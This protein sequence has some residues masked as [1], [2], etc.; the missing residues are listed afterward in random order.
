MAI[1]LK[2]PLPTLKRF[3]LYLAFIKKNCFGEWVSTN[4]ISQ[5]LGIKPITIRKDINYLEIIGAPKKGFNVKELIEK[6]DKVVGADQSDDFALVGSWGFG[7]AFL[8]YKELIPAN[9]NIKLG[10]D[11]IKKEDLSNHI[12]IYPIKKLEDLL[13]RL[14]I[15]NIILS[16]PEDDIENIY[17]KL[18]TLNVDKIWNIS[19][20]YL[21]SNQ[22][23]K[24]YYYNPINNF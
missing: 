7:S 16:V 13:Q 22:D 9:M 2:I 21:P 8:N 6:M 12:P 18:I 17:N 11:Y 1:E 19:P 23:I 3:S 14:A 10:F 4:F 5:S 15:K 20:F 24:I